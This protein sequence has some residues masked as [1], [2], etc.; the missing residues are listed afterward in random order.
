MRTLR[1]ACAL[2]LLCLFATMAN[3][4]II[5]EFDF[6]SVDGTTVP[7]LGVGPAGELLEG[8]QVV[9]GVLR[10]DGV[11]VG[12]D[13]PLG[14]LNPFGGDADWSVQFD[15][16]TEDEGGGPLFSSD[17]SD[18]PDE[19]NDAVAAG[20]LNI[21]LSDEGEVVADAWF[22]GAMGF[23]E[24]LN[25]GEFHTVR[26][27]YTAA[28]SLWALF[29]DDLEEPGAEEEFEYSRDASLDRTRIGDQTNPDFGFEDIDP[30]ADGIVADFDNFLI[31]AP[32]PPPVLV[33]IDRQTGDIVLESILENDFNFDSLTI[34]SSSGSLDTANWQSITGNSDGAGDSSISSANWSIDS[35]TNEELAESGEGGQLSQG[36]TLELGN[37]LWLPS[38]LE[39]VRVELF[40]TD[41]GET[42]RGAISF[43]G[44]PSIFADLNMDGELDVLDWELFVAGYGSDIEGLSGRDA[45]FLSDLNGD[46]FHN[47]EDFVEFSV[48]FDELNGAGAFAALA[49][50]PEPSSLG[51]LGLG[52]IGV[53]ALRRRRKTALPMLML[54]AV[55]ATTAVTNDA[56]AQL[57]EYT[58][59]DGTTDSAGNFDGELFDGIFGDGQPG[60]FGGQLDLTGAVGE[61]M[62]VNLGA[63]NPFDGSGDFTLDMTFTA[64]PQIGESGQLLFSSA[65]F[66]DPTSG[67]NRSISLFIEPEGDIV[68]D[69]FFVGEVRLT[70]PE[71]V[72][73]EE[74]HQ[75][76]VTYTAETGL[77]HMRL[78]DV[79]LTEGE[80]D[81]GVP[82]IADHEIQ[83][84]SSLNEEFP[85]ECFEGECFIREFLGQ[86]D[87]IRIF[88]EAFAPSAFTAEVDRATGDI[89]LNGGEFARDIEFY[90]LTSEGGALNATA[91]SAGNLDQQNLDAL[92][93]GSGETWDTLAGESDR[94]AEAFLFGS[95]F[96]DESTSVT[97]P[98][99][100]SGGSEDLALQIVTTDKQILD[101][102]VSYLG[103]GAGN[104]SSACNPN[105]GGDLTGAGAVTFASFL[106]VSSN[107]GQDVADHTQ[108]DINCSG[109]V[110][111]ADF[112]ILSANFG[113]V[114]GSETASVPEPSGWVMLCVGGLLGLRSRRRR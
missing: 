27:D 1:F 83:F 99:A 80:I 87:D 102:E 52:L 106:I 109:T 78:D 43:V 46:G 58:F 21:F 48:A 112:L 30:G 63:A 42:V 25:D 105:T 5:A 28:D 77:M 98:G 113:S 15:F 72:I 44:E 71:F 23:G 3:A 59:E 97:L 57:A 101:V 38:P 50:V 53:L 79:W 66:N 6:E 45:Y 41:L 67:D 62:I 68:Y 40:D 13:I 92:G 20:S 95:T 65:N 84:G 89:R 29:V 93:D 14:I 36:Q 51:L 9:D 47:A 37:G 4:V 12:L 49:A 56:H 85:F 94:V 7:N 54:A 70:P 104:P 90:E 76:R 88:D 33:N 2:G 31:D 19:C 18:C 8:A 24:G 60:V 107:F 86:L 108:G 64:F 32:A 55:V 110:D 82:D 39:D 111:F 11:G 75:L 91:W 61:A 10:T 103:E 96:F 16:R 69:T 22:I 81:P 35:Q 26:L 34:A 17:S 73:D 114:V 74:P 100:W